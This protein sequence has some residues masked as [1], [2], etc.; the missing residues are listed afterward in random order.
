MSSLQKLNQRNIQKTIKPQSKGKRRHNLWFERAMAILALLNLL[1]VMFDLTYVPLRDFWLQRK[2]QVFSFNIGPIESKGFPIPIP[3]PDITEF[4]DPVKGIEPYRDTQQYLLKV[5]ELQNKLI[6]PGLQSPEVAAILADLRLR[7]EEMIDTNPF[8]VAN[9]TGTLEKIK[10]KMR[11]HIHNSQDSSKEAFRQ[12]WSEENLAA[13]PVEELNFFNDEIRPLIENNYFR[14]IGENGEFK[15]LFGLIDFPFFVIF[16]IEFFSRTWFISRRRTGVSWIDAML[17]RWYDIFLLLP[18][19][20]WLRIIPVTIRLDQAKLFDS[21]RIQK[22]ARQG[23]VVRIA[24]DMTEVVAILLINQVQGAIRQGELTKWL[25]QKE[26]RPYIDLNDTD[27]VA[28]LTTIMVNTTVHQV[29]P[30]I[31]PDLEALLQHNF[32]KV[33]NQS[34]AYQQLSQLPGL[35]KLQNQLTKRISQELLQSIYDGLHLA[36]EEDPVGEKLFQQ[37]LENLKEALGTEVQSKPTIQ[38][39]E[40]LIV[41]FLEEVKVNYVEGLELG[42]NDEDFEELLD[43]KRAIRQVAQR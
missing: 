24:G 18:F 30:K 12:F 26:V 4:Y 17:W 21:N 14:P 13:N 19:A 3:I 36:I 39:V 43:Q 33:I 41:D 29:L 10:N 6:K 34:S 9:K 8:Q 15:D 11:E 35:E 28:A 22:L 32:D 5:D 23:F 37:L 38:E 16:S 31:K 25:M 40:S 42:Y 7:S 20:R 2:I 1:L 27:E